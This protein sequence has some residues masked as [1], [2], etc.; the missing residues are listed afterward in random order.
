MEKDFG[1]KIQSFKVDGG[2]SRSDFLMQVQADIINKELFKPTCIETTAM[3]AAYLAGLKAG[4]YSDVKRL[5]RGEETRFSPKI[6]MIERAERP[7]FQA[8]P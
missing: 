3:G 6:G 7:S 4:F 1:E 5:A 8:P 2:A